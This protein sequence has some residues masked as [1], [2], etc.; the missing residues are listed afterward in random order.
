MLF[1][2]ISAL[3]DDLTN[4]FIGIS[5]G[6]SEQR[7]LIGFSDIG[8]NIIRVYIQRGP[9]IEVQ[10]NK[11]VQSINQINKAVLKYKSNDVSFWVNGFLVET[12][13]SV[14]MPTGL[15]QLVFNSGAG[16]SNFYGNTK[17]VL[18]FKEALTDAEL[19][20]LTS[21]DSFIELA[22]GQQYIIY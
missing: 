5:D 2:E 13:T 10:I 8:S 22:Q 17:Q 7:C 14:T 1:A 12:I 15:N 9:T 16:F 18:T 11:T 4:R 20:N 6:T 3:A 19:E 21:W